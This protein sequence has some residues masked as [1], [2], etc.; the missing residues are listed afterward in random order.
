MNI[1]ITLSSAACKPIVNFQPALTSLL[2][3]HQQQ[4]K[5]KVVVIM[6]ATGSGKSKLA[7][8]LATHFPPAEIVNSD[9]MQVYKGLDITTN[10]VT[11]EESRGVPHHLLSIVDDPNYNFTAND[12]CH[13]ASLAIDSIVGRDGLPIIAGGSNSFIEALVNHDSTFRARYECCFLW[14]DVSLPVLHSS[15]SA[16]VDRM[17][18]AGQLDEVRQFFEHSIYDYT[19]GVRRAIGLPEFDEF[20]REEHSTY[21]DQIKKK[22]LLEA[23]IAM[24]KVNNC[25]LASRQVQ[26]INRLYTIWKNNTYRLNATQSVFNKSAWD[27]DVA[28]KGCRILQKFLYDDTCVLVPAGGP[29]LPSLPSAMTAVTH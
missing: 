23:A 11:E 2:N 12:F 6:G 20:L 3:Q 8:D 1:S 7:I 16:R 13:H 29:L 24:T 15:L 5:D 28:A 18:E 4:R 26:K 19:R 22:K 25:K 10:K 17:I 27:D 9:K 21:A 14:V